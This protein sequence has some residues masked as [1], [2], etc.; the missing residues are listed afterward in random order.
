MVLSANPFVGREREM[1]ELVSALDDALAGHGRLV[2]LAGE[3]GIGKTRI[4]QE[5]AAIAVQRGSVVLWGRCYEDEGTPPYW[6]WVQAL[7]SY[8]RELDAETLSSQMGPG[9][10]DIAEIVSDVRVRLP[11]LEPPRSAMQEQESARFRLFDAITS[12]LKSAS[13]SQCL[14]LIFDNLHWADASSLRLIEFLTPQLAGSS[15]LLI[16]TYRDVDV[17]RGHA[18]YRTLGELTREHNFQRLIIRGLTQEEVDTYIHIISGTNPEPSVA[19]VIH[20]QTEGN[21]LFVTELTRLLAQEG[22]LSAE[23]VAM[24]RI[25]EGI[26]EV[27]GRRLDGVSDDC[28]RV[29]SVASVVGG[30]FDHELLGRL[31]DDMTGDRVLD[32]LEE[33][34]T[35]GLVEEREDNVWGYKF[36]HTLIQQ[37]LSADLSTARRVR[38]HARIAEMLEELY[39]D[40]AENRAAELAHHFSEAEMALGT[41]KLVFYSRVAGEQALATY[42]W[43]DAATHFQRALEAK[44][45]ASTASPTGRGQAGSAMD[46]DTAALLLGLGRAQS[47]AD[48]WEE[49]LKSLARALDYFE[50]V[51]DVASA[52][53]AADCSSPPAA[54]SGFMPIVARVLQMVP[55]ESH[56]AG[57]LL[58]LY[59]MLVAHVELDYQGAQGAFSRALAIARKEGD[60]FLEMWTLERASGT[61]RQFLNWDES[62]TKA[63]EAIQMAP[64]ADNPMA[65]AGAHWSA[66]T[67]LL[68]M[69]DLGR[70]RVHAANT[71]PPAERS[72]QALRMTWALQI[73]ERVASAAGEWD[74]A[75]GFSDRHLA[76]DSP[77]MEEKL[78]SRALLEY[79]TGDLVQCESYIERLFES[80]N[81]RA[82]SVLADREG[83]VELARI[84]GATDHLD[85]VKAVAGAILSSPQVS[86]YFIR[87]A[88]VA[89]ALTAIQ[90]GDDALSAELYV[91]LEPFRSKLD[92]DGLISFDR[93]LGLLAHTMGK[94]ADAA[95]HFED[96]VDFCRKAGCGPELAW[97][98]HDYAALR[99]A[100]RER[101][102][103]MELL[104]EAL[105]ISTELGMRLLMER[106]ATLREQ[107]ESAPARAPAYPDGLTAR[108]VEVL[109]L[110]AS[111]RTNQQIAEELLISLNTVLRH[112]SNIFGKTGSANRADATMYAARKGL[113]S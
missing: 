82:P 24:G 58:S 31:V 112:V 62:L 86:P 91:T 23:R 33:A 44:E 8:V 88:R 52:V 9:A 20:R 75:R 77:L 13:Q 28:N 49:A 6:P 80:R 63:E 3:P 59:G 32:V 96:S 100:Q 69:G 89:L 66:A 95:A 106:A 70:A 48:R 68:H 98:C 92:T 11:D 71:L 74:A 83:L 60:A 64:R 87:A 50:E 65:E 47:F 107:A 109:G 101:E 78:A 113:A 61:D 85:V 56:E 2:M 76:W 90:E 110:I 41:E 104:D 12:F 105:A 108:E 4:A 67:D 21:P 51:G 97:A 34:T 81:R 55:P 16:G 10:T 29:L 36:T 46:A 1:G 72:H 26:Q 43:E 111:G 84:G 19:E 93:L 54:W 22:A 94:L 99:L 53:A 35:A 17:S 103:A 73:S 57:R 7:R 38:L 42:A 14:V 37:A 30:E 39:G 25:P 5:L 40:R 15:L 27:I 45:G 79:Q 102:K 18:L